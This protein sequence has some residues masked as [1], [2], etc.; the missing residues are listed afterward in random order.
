MNLGGVL[1]SQGRVTEALP[2]NERAVQVRP[3]DA[4]AQSQLGQCYLALRR[5]EDAERHLRQA[6]ALDPKHS[7]GIRLPT[8]R[9]LNTLSSVSF[10]AS[11][12]LPSHPSL[13]FPLLSAVCQMCIDSKW[14]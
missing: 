1:L 12:Y 14:E 6:K 9:P 7:Y 4:L 8:A 13:K 10:N 3:D 5:L 2:F 11:K